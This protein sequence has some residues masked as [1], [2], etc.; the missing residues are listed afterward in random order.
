M[1]HR[2][3]WY[4]EGVVYDVVIRTLH[5]QFWL[6]PD[7]DC[8]RIL[9]ELFGRALKLFT[10]V[11]LHVYDAQSNHLHYQVSATAPSQL[12]KFLDYVHG[13]F[14]RRINRLRGRRG[15]LWSRR[16]ATIPVVDDAAQVAR[17]RYVLAQGTAA[18]LVAS[19][20]DWP[21]AASALALLGDRRVAASYVSEAA[22]RKNNRR[23]QPLPEAEIA[24][25]V[26]FELAPLPVWES[27]SRD[28]YRARIETMVAA[29]EEEH[30]GREVMGVER[31]VQ[32]RPDAA[33]KDFQPSPMPLCHASDA[34]SRQT[35]L[36]V[37][38]E[39]MS[40]YLRAAEYARQHPEATV[41]EL[42]RRFPAGAI[43][44]LA[45]YVPAKV[46]A[47]WPW[48]LGPSDAD[49]FRRRT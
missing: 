10:G 46:G 39:F 40:E 27:L 19:P 49:A 28:E 33:P 36:G 17:L 30:A 11:R 15:T 41:E 32:Q 44:R 25:D 22:R 13:M 20:K 23:A 35:F 37:Y 24:E 7:A 9:E 42:S 43:V 6:R 1:A 45:A 18:G 16:A 8:K 47:P 31:L 34:Q 5:G 48:T 12:P 2:Q 4:L 21:G 14:A 29:I 26:S 38:R 3:R